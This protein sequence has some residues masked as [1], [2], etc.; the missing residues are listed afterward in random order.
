MNKREIN[1]S[2][3]S[4]SETYHHGD[5]RKALIDAALT[6]IQEKGVSGLSL[7]EVARV[8]GV[9]HGAPAHH[10]K[11]KKGLLTEIA[12]IGYEKLNTALEQINELNLDP[13]AAFREGGVSYVR[14][15]ANNPAYFDVMFRPE[16]HQADNEALANAAWGA[17]RKLTYLAE[18]VKN[19][20]E[21]E[22][23]LDALVLWAW[24]TGH[25]LAQ[26]WL[27]GSLSPT[28]DSKVLDKAL[29]SVFFAG[30]TA[31]QKLKK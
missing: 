28:F 22:I 20:E 11:D 27:S 3:G 2:D 12:A 9:S 26:L 4:K 31:F 6:L 16:F 8:A 21:R 24:S 23:D 19:K 1:K 29:N 5:L 7:R 15:A 18:Q 14:F 30:E 25:G 13:I 17:H 10:F